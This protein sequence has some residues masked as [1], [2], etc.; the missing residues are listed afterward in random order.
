M[1]HIM[2]FLDGAKRDGLKAELGGGRLGDKGY[3]I[4]PT[5]FTDVSINSDIVF[6][7]F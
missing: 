4:E 5:I 2:K 3:F 1:N 7:I 6:S